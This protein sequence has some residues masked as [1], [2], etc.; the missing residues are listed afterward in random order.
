MTINVNGVTYRL[1]PFSVE[2]LLDLPIRPWTPT[3]EN[4]GFFRV[5]KGVGGWTLHRR[6][7]EA[8]GDHGFEINSSSYASNFWECT[9]CEPLH[10]N[11]DE[12]PL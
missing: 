9:V 7:C 4:A 2:E 8:L 1:C 11:D 10:F 3:A 6:T 12:I 5:T